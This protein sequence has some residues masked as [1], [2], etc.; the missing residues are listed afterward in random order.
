MFSVL[1]FL[2]TEVRSGRG[3][4]FFMKKE[5]IKY[6]D[7]DKLDLRVGEIKTAVNVEKSKKL[8]LLTVDFGEDYGVVEILAGI[9]LSYTPEQLIGN[10]YLFVANLEPR[11]MMGKVSNGMMLAGG[12]ETV[13]LIQVSADIP[14]GTPL[15]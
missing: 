13:Y 11:P 4:M 2:T 14:G 15:H 8:L 6:D 3:I 10:K 7:F 5:L 9:A 12:E 1:P